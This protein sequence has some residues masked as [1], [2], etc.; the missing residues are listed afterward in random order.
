M[1]GHSDCHCDQM[2]DGTGKRMHGDMIG[3]RPSQ[4]EMTLAECQA[5]SKQNVDMEQPSL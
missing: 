2:V 3:K 4:D 1:S 5:I